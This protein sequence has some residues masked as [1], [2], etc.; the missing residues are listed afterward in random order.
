MN[1]NE[2]QEWTRTTAVYKSP[3]YPVL[4]LAEEAGELI[5]K[6]AKWRR[7][8][9]GVTK[10]DIIREAGDVL[11]M[12]VRILDDNDIPASEALR[13]N[14]EKLESRKARNVIHGKGDNR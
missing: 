12:V 10:E 6:F 11:W 2:Y 4:G 5:G 1:I 13:I 7:G 8:D 9:G 14:V 3:D